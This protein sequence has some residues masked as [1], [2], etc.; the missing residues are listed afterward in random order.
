MFF[1]AATT[2]LFAACGKDD[3]SASAA[4]AGDNQMVYN[5]K[6]Y[7]AQNV[8][9]YVN[10]NT[11]QMACSSENEGV[12]FAIVC[13]MENPSNY[14][15]DLTRVDPDHMLNL[16]VVA[17]G[18][19]VQSEEDILDLQ[20][21]NAPQLWYFLNGE[22]VSGSSAFTKGTAVTTLDANTITIT[23]DG[24]LVNGKRLNF[25]LVMPR[26]EN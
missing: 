15:Y 8:E 22:N 11:A 19:A 26:H 14:T 10:E 13:H 9:G 20:Y 5:G 23:L 2:M 7:Q 16:H 17:E 12:G 21:Q 4:T 24:T 18:P 3:E 1:V 6:T 25:R